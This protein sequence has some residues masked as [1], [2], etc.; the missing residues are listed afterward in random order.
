VL[1]TPEVEIRH[2]RGRSAAAAPAATRAAYR[3]SHLAF[4]RK[5]YPALTPLLHVYQLLRG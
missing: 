2:L 3:R 4:Y 5:H 1:F